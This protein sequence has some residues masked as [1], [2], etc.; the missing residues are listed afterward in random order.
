MLSLFSHRPNKLWSIVQQLGCANV[1][2]RYSYLH[3]PYWPS[4]CHDYRSACF[5]VCVCVYCIYIIYILYYTWVLLLMLGQHAQ[6]VKIQRTAVSAHTRTHYTHTHIHTQTL[7]QTHWHAQ[8]HTHIQTLKHWHT[9]VH[10]QCTPMS[11]HAHPFTHTH[12]HSFTHTHT[13]THTHHTHTHT[14]HTHTTHTQTHA[15]R[16]TGCGFNS[17]QAGAAFKVCQSFVLL[18]FRNVA[19]AWSASQKFNVPQ[20]NVARHDRHA[21]PSR[22]R[23]L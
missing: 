20:W 17:A 7:A 3:K 5:V 19:A 11:A 14:H 10:V 2:V 1:S 22:V 21:R 6:E 8:L 13:H 18:Q 23:Q 9:Q 15:Q 4:F 12:A 16:V